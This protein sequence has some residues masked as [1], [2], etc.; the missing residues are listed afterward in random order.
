MVEPLLAFAVGTVA[1]IA[2]T[3]CVIVPQVVAV[4]DPTLA[5]LFFR[6]FDYAYGALA[7]GLF[8]AVNLSVKSWAQQ[9]AVSHERLL[10][11]ARAVT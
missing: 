10:D 11:A 6:E 7:A 9:R 5:G 2:L 4:L 8:V 3:A 1:G